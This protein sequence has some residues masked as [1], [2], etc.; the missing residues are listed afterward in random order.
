[1][2]STTTNN[3]TRAPRGDGRHI[4]R[5]HHMHTYTCTYTR[6]HICHIRIGHIHI[7]AHRRREEMVAIGD[8]GV[9]RPLT[10]P[11]YSAPFWKHPYLKETL[12]YFYT[13]T[14]ISG[15]G[16]SKTVPTYGRLST[17]CV[18]SFLPRPWGLE[19]SHAYT[20]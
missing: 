8:F 6:I 19:F 14:L 2:T 18:S 1:M 9:S 15:T 12:I 20:S 13:K 16:A 17:F 7:Y 10:P 4:Q 5:Y 3:D 11:P